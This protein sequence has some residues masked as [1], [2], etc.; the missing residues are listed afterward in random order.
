MRYVDVLH[1]RDVTV[2]PFTSLLLHRIGLPR[3]EGGPIWPDW[4]DK[5]LA[6]YFRNS[7]PADT[8]PKF[9]V[10]EVDVRLEGCYWIGPIWPHFGHV[11]ADYTTR[12]LPT[13]AENHKA[14]LVFSVMTGSGIVSWQDTPTFFRDV[15]CWYGVPPERVL[16]VSRPTRFRMLHVVAQP[17]RTGN[18]S[19]CSPDPAHL[20][21]LT[22]LARHRLG[23]TRRHGIL[24]VSRS[25]MSNR[26]AGEAYLDK[27]FEVSG[28]NVIHPERM[29]VEEQLHAYAYH[30]TLVFSEGS[31]V[32]GLQLLGRNLG[33]VVVLRRRHDLCFG[34]F[35][36]TPRAEDYT[37]LE[38][39][40][41]F[42]TGLEPDG[43]P[44]KFEGFTI[45]NVDAMLSGLSSFGINLSP[46][47]RW[48][49]FH[50]AEAVDLKQWI[51]SRG[52]FLVS[53]HPKS[54]FT[55][56][57]DLRHSGVQGM[58]AQSLTLLIEAIKHWAP[59]GL[60]ALI[61]GKTRF[62]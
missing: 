34:E 17:E 4:D 1:Y 56:L 42:I 47:W 52:R 13:L 16:I 62:Q 38:T 21:A 31:A 30:D 2:V 32:H 54:V 33:R 49:D 43:E 24:F 44:N 14:V 6:R 12:T 57:T 18:Q 37:L 27:V 59:R 39:S 22:E 7:C 29:P 9:E 10:P 8:R 20:D 26:F 58:R 53:R 28:A 60:K 35:I 5:P 11:V 36:I 25:G 55:L 61:L 50:E 3:H 48:E 46:Y 19:D 23:V 15:L 40:R 51:W 45:L 41:V